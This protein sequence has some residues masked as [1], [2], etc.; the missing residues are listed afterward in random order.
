VSRPFADKIYV[1]S[2]HS[3]AHDAQFLATKVSG[4]EMGTGI[5]NGFIKI[6]SMRVANLRFVDSRFTNESKCM[7]KSL[8]LDVRKDIYPFLQHGHEFVLCR[9]LSRNQVLWGRLCQIMSEPN[10]W[11]GTRSKKDKIFRNKEELLVF[12][13]DDVNVLRQACCASRK[14]FLRLV[15]RDHFR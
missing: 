11:T 14:L 10:F 7:H 5:D 1:I 6:L 15:K 4:T 2:H 13:M 12:C 9:P 8:H 3:R